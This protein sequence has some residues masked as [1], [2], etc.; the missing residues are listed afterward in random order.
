MEAACVA[1]AAGIMKEMSETYAICMDNER[2][3]QNL[4]REQAELRA[5]IE[6][7]SRRVDELVDSLDDSDIEA[8][9][10]EGLFDDID[11]DSLY[12]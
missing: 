2:R 5:G 6:D 1:V 10:E 12:M 7:F 3:I 9:V 8:M 4:E 11:L